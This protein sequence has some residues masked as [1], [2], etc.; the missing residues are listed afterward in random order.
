MGNI[1]KKE[2]NEIID[3]PKTGYYKGKIIYDIIDDE[4]SSEVDGFLYFTNNKIGGFC[5]INY[6]KNSQKWSKIL[7]IDSDKSSYDGYGIIT[8]V[9]KYEDS[10]DSRNFIFEGKYKNGKIQLLSY[11][12][13]I[14]VDVNQIITMNIKCISTHTYKCSDCNSKLD[15]SKIHQNCVCS[16]ICKKCDKFNAMVINT[17]R[18]NENYLDK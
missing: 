6:N 5:G 17:Y 11:V 16:M 4:F 1:N 15:I 3:P 2:Y 8:L 10:N 18:D 7:T 12:D 9:L 14:L 13:I